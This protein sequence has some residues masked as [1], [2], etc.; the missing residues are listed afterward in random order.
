MERI[1]L[2]NTYFHLAY[3]YIF[4]LQYISSMCIDKYSLYIQINIFMLIYRCIQV[5]CILR[6]YLHTHMC[7]QNTTYV[8]IFPYLFFSNNQDMLLK[9]LSFLGRTFQTKVQSDKQ[10]CEVHSFSLR[11]VDIFKFVDSPSTRDVCQVHRIRN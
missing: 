11:I 8:S 9:S 1:I 5:M 3:L 10:Q 4:F 6:Y 2:F 7:I